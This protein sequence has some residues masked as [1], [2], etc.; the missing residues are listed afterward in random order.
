MWTA[1][2]NRQFRHMSMAIGWHI[3]CCDRKGP[4]T[5]KME[6]GF[7]ENCDADLGKPDV[8]RL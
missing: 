3:N 1:G 2:I 6:I 4:D 8:S 7:D 5:G